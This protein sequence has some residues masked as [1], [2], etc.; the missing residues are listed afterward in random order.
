MNGRRR[1]VVSTQYLE[2][3]TELAL[4][5]ADLPVV[6]SHGA[7]VAGPG[8]GPRP[9]RVEV[10]PAR[11]GHALVLRHHLSILAGE[12]LVDGDAGPVQQ[13]VG[14]GV[15]DVQPVLLQDDPLDQPLDPLAD[16]GLVRHLL[17]VPGRDGELDGVRL[18]LVLGLMVLGQGRADRQRERGFSSVVGQKEQESPPRGLSKSSSS[19]VGQKDQK[20]RRVH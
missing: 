11:A 5:L 2:R 8:P 15:V 7:G 9:G 10:G 4:E 14:Q 19:L 6:G 12:L 13:D 3:G 20:S 18:V 16:A 17:R 1:T